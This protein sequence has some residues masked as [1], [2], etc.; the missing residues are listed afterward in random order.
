MVGKIIGRK[1]GPGKIGRGEDGGE[2]EPQTKKTRAAKSLSEK[3]ECGIS[4][5][6]TRRRG[7]E[8]RG[9]VPDV[10]QVAAGLPYEYFV[11]EYQAL[12]RGDRTRG[13]C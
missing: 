5:A 13:V 3:R 7:R 10:S 9:R 4:H 2:R 6:W 12:G 8:P 1:R 11:P